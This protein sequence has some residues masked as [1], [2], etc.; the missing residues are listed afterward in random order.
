MAASPNIHPQPG[1]HPK[2]PHYSIASGLDRSIH[3]S[4]YRRIDLD[5]I[6]RT[7]APKKSSVP[8]SPPQPLV[9]PK[10]FKCDRV[11]IR[12]Q[13]ATYSYDKGSNA[14][15]AL[16]GINLTVPTG[17]IYGLLGPS[18]CGKTTLL[19]C[20][21]G[22][23]KPTSGS[24][25]TFDQP[26]YVP[27]PAIGYMPQELALFLDFTIE[28]TLVYFARI[29]RM[30]RSR[31]PERIKFLV[32]FLDLPDK[33][34]M[35]GSLSGGQKRR[36]SLAVS[37]VHSPPLLILDEPTVGVDPLLRQAIW[38]HLVELTHDK[39]LTVIITT[40]YIEEARSA[41]LCGMMRFGRILMQA[42]PTYLLQRFGMFTLEDV[43]LKVCEL[44]AAN[45]LDELSIDK[46]AAGT[47]SS[48]D[49]VSVNGLEDNH[50][51]CV[52][53]MNNLNIICNKDIDLG[54]DSNTETD[55]S[56]F[57]S[58]KLIVPEVISE[59]SIRKRKGEK[60]CNDDFDCRFGLGNT[61]S[62]TSALLRK[63]ITRLRRNL[64]VLLFQ[65]LLP[66]IEVILF[67]ICIGADPF[68]IPVAIYNRENPAI[69]SSK[70]LD[71][72]DNHTIIQRPFDSLE[73]ALES[74]KSGQTWAAIEIETNFSDALQNRF[75]MGAMADSL[76]I[77][78]SRIHV[79]LDMTNQLV[80]YKLQRTLLESFQNFAKSLLTS[81][82]QNPKV[83][84][85][86]VTFEKPIYGDREPTFT[87]FMAPGII[88]SISFL[89]AI[90]LTA[91]A[92]VM[93][94]KEGLLERSLVAGVT[95]FEFLLSHVLTQ[96]L[97]LSVQV[98][99][100]LIFTFF[101]FD[102]PCRGPSFWVILLTFLQGVCGM[103]YGLMISS[104]CKEE[105]SATMLALGSFYPNLLLSGTV[106]P[107]QAMPNLMRYFSYL[108]PQ[109]I[110]IE[111][112]RY[113]L[114]RGWGPEHPEVAIG[115]GITILW[116]LIFLLAAVVIFRHKN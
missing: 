71:S 52:D 36:V 97:V 32:N 76:T 106:W 57:N 11:A 85:L 100:L 102:I 3:L 94:R 74:V 26:N 64:P 29:F 81:M 48:R 18:G 43:F 104:I 79:H 12:V 4:A 23:I 37:L 51:L 9:L 68:D 2:Y 41:D 19:R 65:F 60:I 113:M 66:A 72:L 27:G 92:F 34:R 15:D 88:L 42:S 8:S 86:P 20:L 5:D 105:N 6:F 44:D 14:V 108:L 24:I 69:F 75:L 112:L 82:G 95:S 55:T 89:M 53:N 61:Y 70:F 39:N 47:E 17:G 99:L 46:V 10:N 56:S 87:E 50:G 30:K 90:A 114:S 73:E 1:W 7:Q 77:E 109:T 96:M 28:E 107:T 13:N 80:S 115:F 63:N 31:I 93:E 58:D 22:R 78:E 91:L 38:N 103:G 59:S 49:I 21:V 54:K 35:I 110:P 84:E 40:H 116:T 98:I 111:S 101:V 62:K 33:N 67:C 25:L 83:I 45:C 16:R